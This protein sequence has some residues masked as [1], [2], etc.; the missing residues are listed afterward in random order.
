MRDDLGDLLA[1]WEFELPEGQVAR[2]P[3]SVR[4]Q[5]RLYVLD[6]P[7]DVRAA[8]T[9]GT[10]AALVRQGDVLVLNDVAVFKARLRASRVSGGAVE[11]MITGPAP[12]GFHAFVRPSR[13]LA[14]GEALRCGPGVIELVTRHADGT[15]L[16]RASPGIDALAEAAGEVPLPPY[17][18][19]RATPEDVER[20]QTVYATAGELRASAAP[21][22]G[23]HFTPHLLDKIAA[24][25]VDVHRV[26]LE[27]G[28]GTFQPLDLPAWEAG[29]LHSER[30]V[31]PSETYDAVTRAKSQGRRVVAVGTTTLRVLESMTG[32]G[33]GATDLFI[34]PGYRFRYVD[35]LITNF[36]LPRSSLLVLVT[37]F[38]G[39][40]RVMAAY[41]DAVRSGFRFYSYGDAMWLD[42]AADAGPTGPAGVASE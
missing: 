10:V 8:R 4:D 40:E 16:V 30:Y 32:P 39:H 37:V 7:A 26:T 13:R 42:R 20:Y 41:G 19:R 12:G 38:G 15:W 34:R 18:D 3:A 35:A 5:S 17:L 23:L 36:H 11:V 22:A 2:E 33:S 9:F 14:E 25:G 31:V 27:V 21:T 28:A 24:L 6:D 1:P 29:R